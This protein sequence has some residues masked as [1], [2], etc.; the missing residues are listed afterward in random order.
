VGAN[1]WFND[2]SADQSFTSSAVPHNYT[3]IMGDHFSSVVDESKMKVP[4]LGPSRRTSNKLRIETDTLID[5]TQADNPILK[6]KESITVPAYDNAAIDSNKVAIF[7]SPSAVIDEDIITS[8]PNLDFDQYIGD[9][10]DQYNEQ[11]TGLK[12]ARNLYWQKYSGPN[13]FWDY[14]RL[15]KYY[16]NSLYRQIRDLVPARANANI[17]I[18]VEPTIL[19]RD[20]VIIG[21]KPDLIPSH[22]ETNIDVI[23]EY[24]SESAEYPNFESNLNFSNP[25]GV[26]SITNETGSVVSASSEYTLLEPSLTYTNPFGINFHTQETGSYI[27]ASAIYQEMFTE[28]NLHREFGLNPKTR[29]TGSAVE[30]KWGDCVYN[31]PSDTIARNANE[32][33][34]FV[35]KTL[36]EAPSLYNIGDV[37]YSGWYG[38]EYY[39]ATI[40]EGAVKS[41][42]EE[43]VQPNVEE[44]VLSEFNLENEYFYSSSLSASKHIPYSS[45]YRATDL[46][47]RWDEFVGTERL[48]YLGCIQTEKTTVT[49]N[50]FRYDDNTPAVEI[51][52]TSPTKLVTT[53]SPSTPLDVQNK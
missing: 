2:V 43:V 13:N 12:T 47:N 10:R 23:T 39:N 51:T 19:E 50:A 48:F 41:I 18:L 17:G 33:G 4:N 16:D 36:L 9:P 22:W 11:Y 7:F 38:T 35:M 44:N 27:T 49:D 52:V 15:L 46:D 14:L 8:M 53:D 3:S 45:S 40:V 1:Q 20:K 28:V 37:D 34:S 25:F 29:Q 31:A 30:W 6:F 21:N 32:T 24:V 26:N 5:K 42:L